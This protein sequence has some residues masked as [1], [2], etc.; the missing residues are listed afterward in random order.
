[1]SELTTPLRI[2]ERPSYPDESR[3]HLFTDRVIR[4]HGLVE[5]DGVY[6][7]EPISA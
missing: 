6:R 5:Q 7:R 4:S 3:C 1:M 2:D